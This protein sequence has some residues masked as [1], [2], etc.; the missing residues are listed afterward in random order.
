M[1]LPRPLEAPVINT[2]LSLK[3]NFEDIL[4]RGLYHIEKSLKEKKIDRISQKELSKGIFKIAFYIMLFYNKE[5]RYTSIIKIEKKLK[6]DVEKIR[7]IKDFLE[8]IQ[9]AKVFRTVGNFKS[10][11]KILRRNL[12]L[13]IVD[14]LKS[15][16]LHKKYNMDGIKIIFSKYFGGFPCLMRF[17]SK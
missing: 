16:A 13:I 5:F 12:I 4:A 10:D 14:L 2:H 3:F 6:E 8:F 7:N 1:A 11:F 15:G 17:I 9:E